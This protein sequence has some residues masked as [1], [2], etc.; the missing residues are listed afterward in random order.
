MFYWISI[1]MTNRNSRMKITLI[2]PAKN[3]GILSRALVFL[4]FRKV[5]IWNQRY[6]LFIISIIILILIFYSKKY[7]LF[8]Y[9]ELIKFIK[10]AY[11][12]WSSK[13]WQNHCPVLM[14]IFGHTRFV[15]LRAH[16]SFNPEKNYIDLLRRPRPFIWVP[17][18][19][20]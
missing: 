12:F 13:L 17:I 6:L 4:W 8:N 20:A 10:V 19:M 16:F 1:I 14:P 9:L 2:S 3:I 5:K 18:C 7:I 11:N 15:P